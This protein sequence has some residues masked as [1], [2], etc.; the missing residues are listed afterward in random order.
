MKQQNDRHLFT[1]DTA[2][3]GHTDD[4]M[5]PVVLHQGPMVAHLVGRAAGMEYSEVR[6]PQRLERLHA[7]LVLQRCAHNRSLK[8][9]GLNRSM[10]DDAHQ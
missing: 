2:L 3:T 8:D 1:A 4:V 6:R 9:S 10:A 7:R 5:V